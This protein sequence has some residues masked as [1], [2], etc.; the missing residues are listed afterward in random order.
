M[1]DAER[2]MWNFQKNRRVAACCARV[3]V[4]SCVLD[5]QGE[6]IA[7][8]DCTLFSIVTSAADPKSFRNWSDYGAIDLIG[9]LFIRL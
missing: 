5:P 4:G 2:S 3:Q 6:V 7:H 1:A 9:G 8:Q